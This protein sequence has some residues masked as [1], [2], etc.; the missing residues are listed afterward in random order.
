MHLQTYSAHFSFFNI[1]IVLGKGVDHIVLIF[2]MCFMNFLAG[3]KDVEMYSCRFIWKY[4]LKS[5]LEFKNFMHIVLIIV[6]NAFYIHYKINST[7]MQLLIMQDLKIDILKFDSA[8]AWLE[9]TG[10]WDT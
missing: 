5:W 4:V 8:H 6:I 2:H 7:F 10:I 3:L 9:Y 1:N